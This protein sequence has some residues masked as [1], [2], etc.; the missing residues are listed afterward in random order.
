[1]KKKHQSFSCGPQDSIELTYFLKLINLNEKQLISY[2]YMSYL[3]NYALFYVRDYK[4]E[5]E[6]LK[7]RQARHLCLTIQ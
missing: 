5:L 7:L 1:M 4:G 6:F 2:T 3:D